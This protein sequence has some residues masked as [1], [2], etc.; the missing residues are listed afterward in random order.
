[1]PDVNRLSKALLYFVKMALGTLVASF[2]VLPFQCYLPQISFHWK[3][4]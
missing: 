1:M 4:E 3:L 2:G